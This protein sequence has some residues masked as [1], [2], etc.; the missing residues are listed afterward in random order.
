MA[1]SAK[2]GEI[3]TSPADFGVE[4]FFREL[5]VLEGPGVPKSTQNHP[6]LTYIDILDLPRVYFGDFQKVDFSPL[7][8]PMW[9]PC[10]PRF[11]ATYWGGLEATGAH[12]SGFGGVWDLRSQPRPQ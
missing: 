4:I 3:F 6:K 12:L 5:S 2:W 9:G 11:T 7:W 10:G 8:A 1:F